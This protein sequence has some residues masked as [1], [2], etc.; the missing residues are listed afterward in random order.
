MS[1][2]AKIETINISKI[3]VSSRVNSLFKFAICH[4]FFKGSL[5]DKVYLD[6]LF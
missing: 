2:E 6:H 1:D 4:F 5:T 3:N